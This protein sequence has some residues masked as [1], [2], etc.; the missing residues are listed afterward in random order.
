MRLIDRLG[1]SQR[2]VIVVALGVAC[3]TAGIYID[4]LGRTA[5]FGW[6]AYAPIS[7]APYSPDT[8]LAGWLLL[9]IWLAL[10]A[11]WALVSIRVLR[12]SPAAPAGD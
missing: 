11:L 1:Q 12:P 8:R 5:A 10:I 6:Y 2:I 7:P 9:I 4:S 3:G